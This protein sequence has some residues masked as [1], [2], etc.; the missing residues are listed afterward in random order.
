MRKDARG[1]LEG[2]LYHPGVR[3]R[4]LRFAFPDARARA[5]LRTMSEVARRTGEM[6]QGHGR[7]EGGRTEHPRKLSSL[8]CVGIVSKKIFKYRSIYGYVVGCVCVSVRYN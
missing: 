2:A 4:F 5:R 3:Y 7:K 8:L 6:P 1:R